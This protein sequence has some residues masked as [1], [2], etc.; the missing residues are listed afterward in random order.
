MLVLRTLH[1]SQDTCTYAMERTSGRDTS[2]PPSSTTWQRFDYVNPADRVPLADA[3]I[4]NRAI[5]Q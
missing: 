5:G 3:I 1:Q 4:E 2:M